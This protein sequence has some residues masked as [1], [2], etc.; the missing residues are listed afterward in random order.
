MISSE[1]SDVCPPIQVCASHYISV[2][3]EMMYEEFPHMHDVCPGLF[4]Y[5]GTRE[6]TE[7]EQR[8]RRR[9]QNNISVTA[10]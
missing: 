3:S 5:E 2:F 4:R 9:Q 10:L 7:T 6:S 8:R 1:N